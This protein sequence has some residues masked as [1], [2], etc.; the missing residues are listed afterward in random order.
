MG[1]QLVTLFHQHHVLALAA[2]GHCTRY[3]WSVNIP[4]DEVETLRPTQKELCRRKNLG[5]DGGCG[6]PYGPAKYH[7]IVY[8]QCHYQQRYC[9]VV[10]PVEDRKAPYN[11]AG[12]NSECLRKL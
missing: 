2:R 10:L 7:S 11:P 4:F 1:L 6:E 8:T 9:P 12:G 5:A 3:S